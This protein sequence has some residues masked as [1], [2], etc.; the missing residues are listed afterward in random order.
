[1]LLRGDLGAGKTTLVKGN[2]W[3]FDAG[4]EDD[5]PPHLHAHPRI[6]RPRVNVYHIDLYRIDTPRQLELWGSTT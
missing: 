1:V 2:R 6:S 3:R 5:V 4:E